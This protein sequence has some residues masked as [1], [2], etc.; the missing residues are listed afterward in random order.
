M[1]LVVAVAVVI[2]K[3]STIKRA[4]YACLQS[5]LDSSSNYVQYRHVV[6]SVVRGE[7]L[8]FGEY[9]ASIIREALSG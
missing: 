5:V 1:V 8:Q 9:V 4:E 6:C 3:V 2:V 7:P